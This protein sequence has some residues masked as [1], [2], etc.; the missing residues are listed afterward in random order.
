MRTIL[1]L[2]IVAV[3]AAYY[4]KD[5]KDPLN[6]NESIDSFVE[7]KA[8]FAFK[9]KNE[10]LQRRILL[11][12]EMSKQKEIRGQYLYPISREYLNTTF[13]PAHQLEL[14]ITGFYYDETEHRERLNSTFTEVARVLCHSFPRH[15]TFTRFVVDQGQIR[16]RLQEMDLDEEP[17][18]KVLSKNGFTHRADSDIS[19]GEFSGFV[20]VR[21]NSSL[22][23]QKLRQL[24]NAAKIFL[25]KPLRTSVFVDTLYACIESPSAGCEELASAK[26]VKCDKGKVDL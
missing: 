5:E 23:V 12:H 22:K 1:L 17:L 14:R 10:K 4:D 6:E 15:L 2:T 18:K 21:E 3:C 16:G 25:Q 26:I 20:A 13:V 8:Y 19:S 9:L 24:N 7:K 11:I